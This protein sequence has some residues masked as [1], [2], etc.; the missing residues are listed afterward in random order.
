MNKILVV[1][2]LFVF[3]SGC[4]FAQDISLRTYMEEIMR[5]ENGKSDNGLETVG[6]PFLDPSFGKMEVIANGQ[7][8]SEALGRYNAFADRIE[9]KMEPGDAAVYV[10]TKSP[11]V[12]CVLGD[13]Q[14]VYVGFLT[15]EGQQ[16]G[17]LQM[18]DQEGVYRVFKRYYVYYR[19]GKVVADP[20]KADVPNK[21]VIQEQMFVGVDGAPPVEVKMRKKDVFAQVSDRHKKLA[22]MVL[23]EGGYN[24]KREKDLVEFFKHLN[25]R[26]ADG[27]AP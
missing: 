8:N 27:S 6:S 20:L 1:V 25:R 23:K 11:E 7:A 9:L 18:L 5:E 3:G 12:S 22:D 2:I 13:R 19:E 4:L 15:D 21:Y 17:Y 10:M 24:L 16:T 26:L 14:F